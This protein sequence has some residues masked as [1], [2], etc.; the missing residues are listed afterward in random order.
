MKP[1][2]PKFVPYRP[3]V[4][5]SPFERPRVFVAPP[6]LPPSR[7]PAVRPTPLQPRALAPVAPAAPVVSAAPN[8]ATKLIA[9]IVKPG[10]S[11]WK[12]AQQ[13]LG[14]GLHWRDLLSVNLGI[15]DANRIVAGSRIY[16]PA[17]SRARTATKI[18]SA[19]WQ[20]QVHRFPRLAPPGR[21]A[22]FPIETPVFGRYLPFLGLSSSV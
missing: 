15:V 17:V 22:N 11:L 20:L 8:G 16:L 10:D 19:P 18:A 2:P 14:K 6:S 1:A 13:N 7:P 5:R 21:T 12:I 3:P 9:V 4:K